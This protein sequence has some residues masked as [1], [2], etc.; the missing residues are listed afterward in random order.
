LYAKYILFKMNV[1]RSTLNCHSEPKL[2]LL[3]N[4]YSTQLLQ[5]QRGLIHVS[6]KGQKPFKYK[7]LLLAGLD[8]QYQRKKYSSIQ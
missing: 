3:D 6:G 2:K 5:G 4:H 7:P 8:N 1:L